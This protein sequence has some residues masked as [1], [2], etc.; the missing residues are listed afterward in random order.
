MPTYIYT[1]RDR[2]GSLR[3]GT[4]ETKDERALAES[5]KS[6]DLIL[7][8]FKTKQDAFNIS[9]IFKH[10]SLT[11]RMIFTRHLEVMARSGIP[12]IGALNILSEQ[13]KSRYFK[14]IIHEIK[15]S[16]EQ[17][18]SFS[19]GV[20]KHRIV[21][22]E[23]YVNMIEVGEMG[24]NLEQVLELLRIQMQKEHDIIS[25]VRGAL[26]Y[27][28]VITVIMIGVGLV[29]LFY[30]MPKLF[31]IFD[32]MNITLPFLTRII[33]NG[34]KFIIA[35]WWLFLIGLVFLATSAWFSLR[36]SKIKMVWN[37]ILFHFPL[38]GKLLKKTNIAR[39]TRILGSL[40]KSGV[41]I[42]N[43]LQTA[44][45]TVSNIQ[46]TNSLRYIGGEVEKGVN[47]S[48]AMEDQANLYPLLVV[49]MVKVGEET[50]NL[51]ELLGEIADFYEAEVND[52]S[53]NLSTI[54]EPFLMVTIGA[55]IGFFAV[56]MIQPMY[57]IMDAI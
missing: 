12:L 17:G 48:K 49:Q 47:L 54:I 36:V 33:I 31:E 32:E 23:L 19:E 39:I 15:S 26:V 38:I 7:T 13:A 6:E 40:L 4:K 35:K 51:A 30:V 45:K 44:S 34:S 46:Y 41:S 11:D 43:A 57:S 14:K 16:I 42:V 27:P 3:Q 2:S 50:G 10:V 56:A 25:K 8:S 55:A 24:G 1:A 37:F 21:F 20:K 28:A 18:S 22:G 29:M 53:K 52:A 9:R 5:L